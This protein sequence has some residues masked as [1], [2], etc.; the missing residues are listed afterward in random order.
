MI[1]IKSGLLHPQQD[2]GHCPHTVIQRNVSVFSYSQKRL[3]KKER[4]L[5]HS[6]SAESARAKSNAGNCL[7]NIS[8]K[9]FSCIALFPDPRTQVG[10]KRI[11][12][13]LFSPFVVYDFAEANLNYH[14]VVLILGFLT[15]ERIKAFFHLK[16]E[17][18][19]IY[20][21]IFDQV[22]NKNTIVQRTR[23]IQSNPCNF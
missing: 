13:Y 1:I 11:L 17:R 22:H 14:A 6:V 16:G 7:S 5:K 2:L 10:E 9:A 15:G 8:A 18:N 19:G 12:I 20:L 21:F 4:N 23:P 3:L